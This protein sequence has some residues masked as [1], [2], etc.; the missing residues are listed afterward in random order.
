MVRK[1]VHAGAD[2]TQIRKMERSDI[3]GAFELID[4]ERWGWEQRHIER[5]LS[6]DEESSLVACENGDVTGV[7]TAL[8]YGGLAFI[9]HLV[10]KNDSRG[11]GL[12]P[13]LLSEALDNMFSNEVKRIELFSNMDVIDFYVKYGFQ[14]IEE[15]TFFTLEQRSPENGLGTDDGLS[16]L[17]R[18]EL[19]QDEKKSVA[20]TERILGYGEEQMLRIL[21]NDPPDI[22]SLLTMDKEIQ[23]FL[24]GYT[25]DSYTDLGPWIVDLSQMHRSDGM[26]SSIIS[27]LPGNRFDIGVSSDNSFVLDMISKFGFEPNDRVMRMALSN[28]RPEPYPSNVISP[29]MF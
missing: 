13:A 14:S 25:V 1:S 21:E 18:L 19:D 23:G 28:P 29:P 24:I 20:R 10:I 26:L 22:T 12:G 2:M 11:A 3:P 6:R 17:I 8:R 16:D 9:A 27:A 15:L 4:R 5:I 7:L